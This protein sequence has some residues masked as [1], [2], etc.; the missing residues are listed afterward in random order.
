MSSFLNK[1]LKQQNVMTASALEKMDVDSTLFAGDPQLDW[2]MG[3]WS[4]NRMNLIYGPKGSGKSTLSLLG[5]VKCQ[6]ETNG[7]VIIYDS[8]YYF[9]ERPDRMQRLKT[10]G[11]DLDKTIIISSNEIGE[12]F[13]GMKEL[14]ADIA[15]N[16]EN[17]NSGLNVAAIIVD[18]V[19]GIQ[20]KSAE[21]KIQKNKIEEAGVSFGGNAKFI[22]PFLGIFVRICAS[23]HVTSFFV[24]HCMQNMEQYGPKWLLLG[25]QRLQ[26]LSDT[27][28]L[29]ESSNAKDSAI[30]SDGTL[31][32]DSSGYIVKHGKKILCKC[33]KSRNVV[34]G[35][36]G[37][38]YMNF[39]DCT[40]ARYEYSLFELASKLGV[41][42]HPLNPKNG[43]PQVAYWA[44]PMT[45][46]PE[47]QTK[48]HGAEGAVKALADKA[49]ASEIWLKCCQSSLMTTISENVLSPIKKVLVDE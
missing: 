23:H 46:A 49:L 20:S 17:P 11:F 8:E 25:G 14:E 47:Q 37:E 13:A 26:F 34:E 33:D 27:I 30:G 21:D 36:T 44:Y 40:F 5:A 4:R 15:A 48:W 2:V 19:G 28:L 16:R 22:N 43:T 45:A 1:L 24:Q 31:N 9:H 6:K 38:F 39:T 18:S 35:R 41:I 29:V 10:M 3:G 7:Y 42:G 32:M 12:L